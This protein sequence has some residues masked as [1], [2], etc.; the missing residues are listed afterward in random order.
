[1][2]DFNAQNN[3]AFQNLYALMGQQK[4]FSSAELSKRFDTDF[5]NQ[6]LHILLKL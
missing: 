6:K 5:V 1:M 4:K 2:F 3:L